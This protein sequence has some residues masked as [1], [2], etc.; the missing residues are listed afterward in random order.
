MF[1]FQCTS[2]MLCP[3]MLQE[4][5]WFC[6][7]HYAEVLDVLLG[8]KTPTDIGILNGRFACF[9]FL[10]VYTLEVRPLFPAKMLPLFCC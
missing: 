3:F 7:S 6:S 4:H 8:L 9:H 2:S 1:Y 10:M 5:D